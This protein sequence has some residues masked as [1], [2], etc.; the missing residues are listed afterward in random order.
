[1]RKQTFL[2]TAVLL[3]AGVI[4]F[5]ACQKSGTRKGQVN[6]LSPHLVALDSVRLVAEKFNPSSYAMR[7]G[8]GINSTL[9]GNNRVDL[10]KVYKDKYGN[11]AFYVFN[12]ENKSG[13]IFVSADYHLR[14]V[15]AFVDNGS[16]TEKGMPDGVKDWINRTIEDV[17]MVRGGKYDNSKIAG[18]AWKAYFKPNTI[19]SNTVPSYNQPPAKDPCANGPYSTSVTVGPLLPVTWGQACTYNDLCAT[20]QIFNC[21]LG[22]ANSRPLTGC[23][24]TA[25]AQVIRYHQ[26]P[27]GYNYASMPAASGNAAVQ[28]LMSDA[29]VSVNMSYGC[30][31]S[32]AYGNAIPGAFINTFHYST[33][34]RWSYTV[35][36]LLRMINNIGN[37]WPI[38]MEGVDATAGGHEWV[39]DGYIQTT[40]YFCSNGAYNA[41]EIDYM[42]HMN[43]GW[44]EVF[45]GTD[46]N[47][48]FSFDNWAVSG[49]NFQYSR[50]VTSEIH[51]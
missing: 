41:G 13:F 37:H 1:M 29:G 11:P 33:A 14:P 20:N 51:P 32:G 35:S 47:G 9:N 8:T 15:L 38:L 31:A 28:Q 5:V 3:A 46:F 23:V 26:F 44:H 36:N 45:G 17:E 4:I 49:L 10:D 24:A 21:N 19:L 7:S 22:C 42:L 12:F 43:W 18:A 27:S 34:N 48:W 39:G 16:F 6:V 2:L 30:G 25:M 50:Y 40:Y